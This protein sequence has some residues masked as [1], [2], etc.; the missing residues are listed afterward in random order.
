[1]HTVISGFVYATVIIVVVSVPLLI[2]LSH[3]RDDEQHRDNLARTTRLADAL[4]EADSQDWLN[5]LG[6]HE[7]INTGKTTGLTMGALKVTTIQN[8]EITIQV[9]PGTKV[10][11]VIVDYTLKPRVQRLLADYEGDRYQVI[12]WEEVTRP[13]STG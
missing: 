1:M 2:L 9:N 6:P 13:H 7:W 10:I 11:D 5:K 8:D 12:S 4:K 3:L